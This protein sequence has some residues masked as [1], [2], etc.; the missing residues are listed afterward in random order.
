MQQSMQNK[1]NCFVGITLTQIPVN[2]ALFTLLS[3]NE[4]D[5][6]QSPVQPLKPQSHMT[7][8]GLETDRL[9][10]EL[11]LLQNNSARYSAPDRGKQKQQ[12]QQQLKHYSWRSLT[13]IAQKR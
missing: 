9:P 10:D 3:V 13:C 2:A 1:N 6:R 4:T 11:F 7:S 8:M 12:Q 5:R